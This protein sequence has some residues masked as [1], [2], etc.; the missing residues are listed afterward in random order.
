MTMT[1]LEKTAHEA[2]EAADKSRRAAADVSTT[3]APPAVAA[4]AAA[5]PVEP[6]PAAEPMEMSHADHMRQIQA[7]LP[8]GATLD[9]NTHT[10]HDAG[11]AWYAQDYSE[12]DGVMALDGAPIAIQAMSQGEAVSAPVAQALRL[13]PGTTAALAA[14]AIQDERSTAAEKRVE[15]TAE[16]ERLTHA[17]AE[18]EQQVV[19]LQ[20]ATGDAGATVTTLTATIEQ[21]ASQITA[22]ESQ[23]AAADHEI[24]RAVLEAN[25]AA[26][27]QLD[28]LVLVVTGS[29]YRPTAD[30]TIRDAVAAH[31]AKVGSAY[32]SAKSPNKIVTAGATDPK[33]A[34][35]APAGSP[36]EEAIELPGVGGMARMSRS[37]TP[38]ATLPTGALKRQGPLSDASDKADDDV[39]GIR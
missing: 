1:T 16:V 34:D 10:Y 23:V 37:T 11:G 4:P 15:L 38:R 33:T 6:S 9:A 28:D 32:A 24:A 22:L 14:K 18:R 31:K 17:L 27:D 26:E 21:Q 8:E 13:A 29:K 30:V 19:T 39:P 25:G 20:S 3:L 12:M 2:R 5:P 7:L 35:G 36:S